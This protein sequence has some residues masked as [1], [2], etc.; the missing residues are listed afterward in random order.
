MQLHQAL[1]YT[2]RN[3]KLSAPLDDGLLQQEKQWMI[4]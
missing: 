3:V 1:N 2:I 4:L